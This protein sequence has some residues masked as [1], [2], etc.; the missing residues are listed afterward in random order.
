MAIGNDSYSSARYSASRELACG[1]LAATT[2]NSADEAVFRH[3]FFTA[4]KVLEA[5]ANVMV[6]GKGATSKFNIYKGTS[7]IGAIAVS[8]NTAGVVVNASLTDTDC[9]ATDDLTIKAAIATDT[10]AACIALQFQ[11][12]FSG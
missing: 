10:A 8:T 6:A 9:A 1:N 11:E 4:V 3:R 12:A 5:R 2:N 7:S